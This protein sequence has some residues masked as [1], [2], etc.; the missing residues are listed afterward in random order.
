M[1][2]CYDYEY[3]YFI[4]LLYDHVNSTERIVRD[5]QSSA[6]AETKHVVLNEILCPRA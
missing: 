6:S 5:I 2:E 3:E 4:M 1:V